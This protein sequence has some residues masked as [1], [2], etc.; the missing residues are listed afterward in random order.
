MK[1][2]IG[3]L[4]A[5]LALI[6]IF[7]SLFG[8]TVFADRDLR[9]YTNAAEI[10]T[11]VRY[12]Y[13]GGAKG[14]ISITQGTLKQGLSSKPVYFVTL[15]GTELVLNQSTEGLTDLPQTEPIKETTESF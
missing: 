3:F 11:L 14:P 12:G 2:R 8:V 4:A 10:Y 7:T 1:R 13:N 6:I 5:L 15:S 9:T